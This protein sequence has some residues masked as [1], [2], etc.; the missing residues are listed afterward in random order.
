M[1]KIMRDLII[2]SR[3]DYNRTSN[4]NR[5]VFLCN[6]MRNFWLIIQLFAEKIR[7]SDWFWKIFNN[8]FENEEPMFT[9]WLLKDVSSL[10][11]FNDVLLDDEGNKCYRIKPNYTL[12]EIK[13]KVL[14]SNAGSNTFMECLRII[15]PLLCNFWL[16]RAKIE[17]FQIIWDYYSKRLN[18]SNKKVICNT[19]ELNELIDT[20]IWSPRNCKGDFEVFLGMLICHLREYPTH[21]GKMKGRIYSQL[22]PNKLKDLNEIGITH[23]MLLFMSLASINFNELSKKI[24]SFVEYLPSEKKNTP[25]VWKIYAVFLIKHVKGGRNLENAA[26]L[27]LQM[28]QDAS[29]DQKKFHLINEFMVDFDHIINFS[30]NM[31]LCQWLLLNSWISKYMATCYYSYLTTTL[32]ILLSTLDK[33]N[34]A[35]SWSFWQPAF[36]EHIYPSLKQISNAPT[37]PDIIGKIAGKLC[38]LIPN[39]TGES[40][41][42]FNSES[43]FP[44]VSC[45][46]LN[47]VL[48]NHSSFILSP[49]QESMVLQS[50]VKICLLTIDFYEDITKYVLKLDCFPPQ[51]KSHISTSKDPIYAFIEYLGTDIRQHIQSSSIIKLCELSFGQTDRWL[52]KYLVQPE[53]EAV[54]FRIY[55]C[56]SLAFLHCGPLLYDRN[57]STSPLTRLV[58][59]LLLP[60]EFLIGKAPHAFVLNA[61]KKTWHLFFEAIVKLNNITDT[62]LERTLRDMILK[63]IPY[64]STTDSPIIKC[65]ENNVTAPVILDKISI[66]YF[67][68]PVKE[69]DANILKVLK[70]ISDFV[71]S[72]TSLP[73]MRLIV[74][75]T[76]YGLFEVVIFHAQR[77]VA[78]SVVKVITCSPLYPQ[79][80][81]DFSNSVI[82]ITEKHLAFNTINYFQL[83]HILAKFIPSDIKN[84]LGNIKQHVST[85]ERMRGVGFDKNLRTLF[86][87][88][89]NGVEVSK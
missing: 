22:G 13:L 70:I 14:L 2:I 48:E 63:Y 37:V 39:L 18:V 10:Q 35:D 83:M 85:V 19:L 29:C 16:K 5:Q 11:C 20:I 36:K 54:V 3:K 45:Q 67:K 57:K 27:M 81:V 72:T 87:K 64:F 68:H 62:F 4:Q 60:T 66:S 73:L 71:Q 30:T 47:V 34:N 9:L 46:F 1:A 80:K 69:S 58:Q 32:D 33:V 6:C 52:T 15:E 89:E 40:F 61:V 50:W 42:F 76:L 84:L 77:N 43:M 41:S 65:F 24:I 74:N 49:Q 23:V 12:L 44:Q 86:E 25:I 55:T 53:N 28:L 26:P 17:V 59:V 79:I 21:W 56:I 51:L 31:Q 8:L 7:D 88:L 78:I 38:L 82:A 75:K